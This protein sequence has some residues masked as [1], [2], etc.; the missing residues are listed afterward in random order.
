MKLT[1]EQKAIRAYW[2]AIDK[3]L[4]KAKGKAI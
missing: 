4:K 3:Q 1:K 2:K